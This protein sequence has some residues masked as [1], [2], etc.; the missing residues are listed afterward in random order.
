[1][2]K[3]L[4]L[5]MTFVVSVFAEEVGSVSTEFIL[6]GANHKIVVESFEDP[7]VKGVVCFASMA[8][9]GGLKGTFGIAEDPNEVSISCQKTG[10]IELDESIRSKKRDGE[11]VFKESA[12]FFFKKIR[13]VRF[14]DVKHNT[15]IYLTY[16]DKLIEGSPK[17][18]ITTIYVD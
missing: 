6:L 5:M 7:K 18:S 3:I 1:M 14:Y 11:L 4:I 17:N 15:L 10:K 8:K 9:T 13:V 16:S 12:S 2:K